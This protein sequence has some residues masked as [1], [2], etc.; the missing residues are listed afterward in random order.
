[1]KLFL[2]YLWQ[3]GRQI[4]LLL[5]FAAILTAVFALY[6]LPMEALFYGSLLCCT[7]GILLLL[8]GYVLF[9]RR[10]RLLLRLSA[11]DMELE[12]PEPSGTL[13]AD[14]QAL[15]QAVC[16]DRAKLA[17]G[18]ES[19]RQEL[20][21]YYTL[22]LHQIKTPIAA[23]GLLLTEKPLGEEALSAELLKIES[24]VSMVLTYLRLGSDSTDFVLRSCQLDELVRAALR[25]YARL[26]ILRHISLQFAVTGRT[27][28]TDDKWLAFVLEQI[29]LNALKYTPDGGTIRV[30]GNGE[31]LAVADNGIGIRPEDLPRVF[32]KGFTGFNGREENKA[33]G[34]GLYL[35]RQV[36]RKLG[37]EITISSYP[38]AGTEVRLLLRE[39]SRILE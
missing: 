3:K 21:D 14:Y 13:E 30:F 8:W 20:L 10:H 1:M 38:G 6:D 15:L 4:L 11:E 33:T 23:M 5:V 2:S 26:F 28:L 25:K 39:G 35:S 32:E 29:L 12:L 18:A 36:L 16:A 19:Q 24:Y 27:I 34:L 37:G 22:W 7:V 9:W 17:A 31:V